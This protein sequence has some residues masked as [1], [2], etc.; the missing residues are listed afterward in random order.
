MLIDEMCDPMRQHPRLAGAR[1]RDHQNRSGF[2]NNGLEL[3][4]IKPRQ[5]V[6]AHTQPT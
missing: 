6:R 4:R 3:G 1:A 5:C 2:G